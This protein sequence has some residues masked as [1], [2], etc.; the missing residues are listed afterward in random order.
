MIALPVF[1]NSIVVLGPAEKPATG[2]LLNR[3]MHQVKLQALY[4]PPTVV[5]QLLQESGGLEKAA[6]LDFVLSTGGPLSPSAGDRLAKVT[7]VGQFIGS[8]EV[9]IIPVLLPERKCWNYFEWHPVYGSQMQHVA[10]DIYE[11]VI[12]YDPSLSWLRCICRTAP[13]TDEWRT[14]DLF[15]PH[16]SKPNLWKFHGRTDDIIVLSNG[17]KFNPVTMEGIIQGHPLL[18]GALIVGQGRFQAALMVEL[19]KHTTDHDSLIEE[20]W[21]FV[22]KA[23]VEGPAHAQI[24]RSKILIASLDKPFHRV[25]K[26]TVVRGLTTKE[27]QPELE[28]LYSGCQRTQTSTGSEARITVRHSFHRT[29][30]ARVREFFPIKPRYHQSRRPFH[31]WS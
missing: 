5:E 31:P 11:L 17:E 19:K 6:Q 24:F 25:G 30:C 2:E 22:Q 18:S 10:E 9:G 1:H 12:P 16:P 28:A 4:S 27:Y 20:I 26:G 14:K 15:R 8:T 29:I 21:P 7:N 23:N 13:E 3:I